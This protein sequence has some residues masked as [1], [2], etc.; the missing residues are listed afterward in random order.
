MDTQDSNGHL[1]RHRKMQRVR[2]CLAC[3]YESTAADVL[4]FLSFFSSFLPSRWAFVDFRTTEYA[5]AALTNPKNH[6]LNGRKLVVEYASPE[7]VRRGGAGSRGKKDD[8]KHT[9]ANDADRPRRERVRPKRHHDDEGAQHTET[10]TKRRRTEDD[11]GAAG[12]VG[13]G[14]EDA[15]QYAP[16]VRREREGWAKTRAKPG[17][18]LANAKRGAMGIV[19]SQG[20]K[21]V[22]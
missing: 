22:F 11:G 20:K 18:A 9:D 5:T 17:A 8:E 14:A 16:R 19:P 4:P 6:F 10:P 3:N 1:R 12:A 21:I 13:E 7:A 15:P 2:R